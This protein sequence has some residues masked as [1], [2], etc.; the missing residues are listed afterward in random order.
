[1]KEFCLCIEDFFKLIPYDIRLPAEEYYRSLFFMAMKLVNATIRAEETTRL[2]RSDVVIQMPQSIAM[3]SQRVY[4][5]EFKYDKT[6]QE[7]LDQIEEKKY[8]EP[9]EIA[10][11][12]KITFIGINYKSEGR[13]IQTAVLVKKQ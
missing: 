11:Y 3:S 4:V 12:K 5:L 13:E 8:Y 6:T 7:A 10:G 2:G 1:M 9:Y